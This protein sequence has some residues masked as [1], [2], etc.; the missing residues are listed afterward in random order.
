MSPRPAPSRYDETAAKFLDAAARLIDAALAESGT[1]V[2]ARL[3]ALHF[4]AALEWMRAEDVVRTASEGDET[5]S[6]KAFRNRWASK[7]E[8][9]SD[10]IVHAMLYRDKGG[11]I[12]PNSIALL[13]SAS[14]G[15][16]TLSERISS[17]T[18]TIEDELA[19]S[20][21]SWLLAHIAPLL[22]RHPGVAEPVVAEIRAD[23]AMWK[24]FFQALL[25]GSGVVMRPGWTAERI[26]M[27]I[28][29]ILDG[30]LLRR[31]VDPEL[32]HDSRWAAAHLFTDLVLA[33]LC[34]IADPDNSGESVAEWMDRV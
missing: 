25:D 22:G 28:Q 16:G 14:N 31:R 7:D 18:D 3:R 13:D 21:R 6:R 2:P 9:V 26:Q 17:V 4:P 19:R 27:A 8:F 23:Q 10:A 29:C 5:A 33:F 24:V 1:E 32:F 20:P 15:A 30:V 34:G 11:D 12:A